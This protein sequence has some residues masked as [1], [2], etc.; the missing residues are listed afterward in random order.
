[1]SYAEK[2]NIEAG[3]IILSVTGKLTKLFDPETKE[4]PNKP[5]EMYVIQNG[6]LLIDGDPVRLS[7]YGEG[8]LPKT[9]RGREITLKSHQGSKG[10]N[11]VKYKP[12]FSQKLKAEVESIEASEKAEVYIDGQPFTGGPIPAP[13]QRTNAPSK[14]STAQPTPTLQN[15]NQSTLEDV[16]L[17]IDRVHLTCSAIVKESYP[18]IS[19]EMRQAYVASYFIEANR[20]GAMNLPSKYPI[21]PPAQKRQPD[22]DWPDVQD[23]DQIPY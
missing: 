15:S 11:G 5:G 14:P 3:Q 22:P 20:N 18:N 4:R 23:D 17:S 13:Q 19:D 2:N 10:I 9:A 12:F 16:L 6:E 8:S 21:K 1:M 7:L